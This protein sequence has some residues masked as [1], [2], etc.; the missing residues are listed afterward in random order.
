MTVGLLGLSACGQQRDQA[1]GDATQSCANNVALPTATDNLYVPYAPT[2][3]T[4]DDLT[5]AEVTTLKQSMQTRARLSAAAAA[6]DEYWQPLADAW[7]IQEARLN[8]LEAAYSR[9]TTDGTALDLSS[10]R[11]FLLDVNVEYSIIMK[12]TYCR[13][14]ITRSGLTLR[15]S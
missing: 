14:A 11:Q 8:N 7:A 15:G 4:P 5:L 9:A 12:D 2:L 10:Y 1:L 13:V 3:R 6:R